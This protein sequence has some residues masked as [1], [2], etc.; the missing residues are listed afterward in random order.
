MRL[1]EAVD[2][3][4][5]LVGRKSDYTL[6]WCMYSETSDTP[7]EDKPP[8]KGQTKSTLVYTL[9]TERGQPLYKGQNAGS[10]VCPLFGGFTVVC[11]YGRSFRP[12]QPLSLMQP[13]LKRV[14]KMVESHDLFVTL[15]DVFALTGQRGPIGGVARHFF[16]IIPNRA[17]ELKDII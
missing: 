17:I 4:C 14:V 1:G 10:Q 13:V 11:F 5:A 3:L 9:H 12:Y 6:V 16:R 8:N 2:L 7:R 15:I